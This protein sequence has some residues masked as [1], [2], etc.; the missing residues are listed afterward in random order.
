MLLLVVPLTLVI[1]A[2]N[3]CE[4]LRPRGELDRKEVDEITYSALVREP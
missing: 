1:T 4:N 2:I 3:Y